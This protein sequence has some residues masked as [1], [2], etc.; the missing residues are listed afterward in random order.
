MDL[1]KH[2][3]Q[4]LSQENSPGRESIRKRTGL[5]PKTKPLADVAARNGCFEFELGQAPPSYLDEDQLGLM[6]MFQLMIGNLD[7]YVGNLHNLKLIRRNDPADAT[8]YPVPYDFDYSGLINARYAVPPERMQVESVRDRCYL[9]PCPDEA[10][11]EA[12]RA[13]FLARRDEVLAIFA[14]SPYLDSYYRRRALDYLES[15]CQLL[16]RPKNLAHLITATC[17]R[18]D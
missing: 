3:P 16:E 17:S 15:F 14:D 11:I 5:T 1:D 2:P 18:N 4:S 13:E 7:W 8:I 12:L 10:R 6:S 9:G